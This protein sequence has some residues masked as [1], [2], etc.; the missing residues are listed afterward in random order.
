M[1]IRALEAPRVASQLGVIGTQ[2]RDREGVQGPEGQGRGLLPTLAGE[3]PFLSMAQPPSASASH[4]FV[5]VSPP[6][7]LLF[8]AS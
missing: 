5:A 2:L 1:G 4:T 8:S 6:L 7:T 3:C